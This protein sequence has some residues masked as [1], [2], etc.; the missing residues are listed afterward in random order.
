METDF[1]FKEKDR[2]LFF[3]FSYMQQDGTIAYEINAHNIKLQKKKEEY[4]CQG[5]F[6][7]PIF[8]KTYYANS[9]ERKKYR[10]V[11]SNELKLIY[12]EEYWK[13]IEDIYSKIEYKNQILFFDTVARMKVNGS[14]EEN[15][16]LN[17]YLTRWGVK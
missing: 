13:R 12:G 7:A 15:N 5:F 4:E 10:L 3:G 1:S 14:M 11:F 2:I 6:V 17:A 8:E 16:V 9:S